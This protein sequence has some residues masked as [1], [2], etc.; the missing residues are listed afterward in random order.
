MNN[1]IADSHFAAVTSFKRFD[2]N[3]LI[4]GDALRDGTNF[5]NYKSYFG[6]PY[7]NVRQASHDFHTAPNDPYMGM[8]EVYSDW[9]RQS[10]SE[11]VALEKAQ[12]LMTKWGVTKPATYKYFKFEKGDTGNTWY[13][14]KFGLYTRLIDAQED[15]TGNSLYNIPYLYRNVSS[16][17]RSVVGN[18]TVAGTNSSLL[19]YSTWNFTGTP[20]Y[21]LFYN[22]QQSDTEL[23]GVE[24]ELPD[25]YTFTH[26]RLPPF[27][28]YG[29]SPTIRLNF[30]V[31]TDGNTW[32][33]K[34]L[35]FIHDSTTKYT[36]SDQFLVSASGQYY[37]II[38]YQRAV[39]GIYEIVDSK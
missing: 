19:G 5:N 20:P 38:G 18:A 13:F 35:K 12:Q 26:I 21:M 16:V 4:A 11:S 8:C 39:D 31:S 17:S 15:S 24:F 9:S 30:Y 25:A 28:D 10:I 27:G 33:Q 1:L 34:Y 7:S 23:P 32:T 36:D 22:P 14:T 2:A 3:S 29:S 6:M 37:G